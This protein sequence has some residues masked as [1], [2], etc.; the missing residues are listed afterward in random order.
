[1]VGMEDKKDIFIVQLGQKTNIKASQLIQI[2][3]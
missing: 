1:M 2:N 3:D